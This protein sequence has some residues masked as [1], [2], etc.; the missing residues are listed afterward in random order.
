MQSVLDIADDLGR[1]RKFVQR[2][3]YMCRDCWIEA[4]KHK[5]RGGTTPKRQRR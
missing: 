1:S 4:V 2:W 5:S 3:A